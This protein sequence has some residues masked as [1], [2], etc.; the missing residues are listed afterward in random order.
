MQE[1]YK[2]FVASKLGIPPALV[3]LGGGIASSPAIQPATQRHKDLW[4]LT[5]IKT[6]LEKPEFL[7]TVLDVLDPSLLQFH[8]D[9]FKLALKNEREHPSV[10]DVLLDDEIKALE[11]FDALKK[12]LLTYLSRHYERELK[13]INLDKSLSFEKKA[14]LIRKFRD[15]ITRLKQGELVP[16]D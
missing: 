10:M 2:P 3:R 9:V 14:F 11:S 8:R 15:K 1:E 13:K 4:E 16:L 6:I 12:E 5:L 7:D